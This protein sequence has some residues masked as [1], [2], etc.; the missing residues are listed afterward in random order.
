MSAGDAVTPGSA[1]ATS[2]PRTTFDR[3]YNADGSGDG[4]NAR[5][6]RSG[7]SEVTGNWRVAGSPDP[8]HPTSQHPTDAHN[9]TRKIL[10]MPEA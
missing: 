10:L 6:G 3:S 7:R 8:A 9:D 4:G 2:G 1:G 5:S